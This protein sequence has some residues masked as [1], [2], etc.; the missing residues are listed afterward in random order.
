LEFREGWTDE[1][2]VLVADALHNRFPEKPDGGIAV[3]QRFEGSECAANLCQQ[4]F[5]ASLRSSRF[6]RRLELLVKHVK[7]IKGSEEF[8]TPSFVETR[9]TGRWGRRAVASRP[10]R[11]LEAGAQAWIDKISGWL[12]VGRC[13]RASV[14]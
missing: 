1:N 8:E 9:R 13:L 6:A 2:D 7:A 10:A 11:P 4:G 14:A 5:Y 12:E 3:L